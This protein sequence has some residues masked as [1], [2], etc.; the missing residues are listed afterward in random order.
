MFTPILQLDFTGFQKS[1]FTKV[2]KLDPF[3]QPQS[4]FSNVVNNP[5]LHL[6]EFFISVFQED[7][8]FWMDTPQTV[9]QSKIS[10]V[11]NISSSTGEIIIEFTK[12]GV[13][14]EFICSNFEGKNLIGVGALSNRYLI[15]HNLRQLN[16]SINLFFEEIQDSDGGQNYRVLTGK[17]YVI[18]EW[19]YVKS[20]RPYLPEGFPQKANFNNDFYGHSLRHYSYKKFLLK[21]VSIKISEYSINFS[22]TDEY[23]SHRRGDHDGGF[24]HD[25]ETFNAYATK[26]FSSKTDLDNYLKELNSKGIFI[27][28]ENN[29]LINSS[30]YSYFNTYILSNILKVKFSYSYSCYTEPCD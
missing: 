15:C 7:G 27:D 12:D 18:K 25:S 28:K 29:C 10:N 17:V 30:S 8:K 9:N 16:S 19:A 20:I 3:L 5:N 23:T 6:N 14:H 22:I 4:E 13:T 2:I 26:S 11:Y 24:E 21:E 1:I